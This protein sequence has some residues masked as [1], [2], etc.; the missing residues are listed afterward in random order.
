MTRITTTTPKGREGFNI[1]YNDEQS[2][3]EKLLNAIPKEYNL[4][5]T[6]CQI[7]FSDVQYQIDFD[8]KLIEIVYNQNLC[9]WWNDLVDEIS[10]KINEHESKKTD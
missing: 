9:Y 8:K 7:L 3:G 5:F 10:K 6:W 4:S 1:S 2:C